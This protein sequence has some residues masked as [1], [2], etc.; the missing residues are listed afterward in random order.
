MK[1]TVNKA[2]GIVI[3]R[4]EDTRLPPAEVPGSNNSYSPIPEIRQP[5]SVEGKK[6][7]DTWSKPSE[8]NPAETGGTK[9]RQQMSLATSKMTTGTRDP[10]IGKYYKATT[11]EAGTG[12]ENQAIASGA[13]GAKEFNLFASPSLI[14]M[15]TEHYGNG[16]RGSEIP[17]THVE[18]MKDAL[19]K[20]SQLETN[21]S[22]SSVY[23]MSSSAQ[24]VRQANESAKGIMAD[25]VSHIYHSAQDPNGPADFRNRLTEDD[26]PE[27]I[28]GLLGEF[29]KFDSFTVVRSASNALTSLIDDR[30][31]SSIT[32]PGSPKRGFIKELEQAKKEEKRDSEQTVRDLQIQQIISNARKLTG[33][34][35]RKTNAPLSK[36]GAKEWLAGRP[37]ATAHINAISNESG[38]PLNVLAK[39][40]NPIEQKLLEYSYGSRNTGKGEQGIH[41]GIAQMRSNL[42]DT[43]HLRYHKKIGHILTDVL[44][45]VPSAASKLPE[46]KAELASLGLPND[47]HIPGTQDAFLGDLISRTVAAKKKPGSSWGVAIARMKSEIHD[48]KLKGIDPRNLPLGKYARTI[49]M[50]KGKDVSP[51]EAAKV[52][53]GQLGFSDPRAYTALTEEVAKK[54]DP[55]FQS[56]YLANVPAELYVKNINHINSLKR[57]EPPAQPGDPEKPEQIEQR[58]QRNQAIL[59]SVRDFVGHIPSSPDIDLKKLEGTIFSSLKDHADVSD[60][61]RPLISDVI[62]WR[63]PHGPRSAHAHEALFAGPASDKTT[64]NVETNTEQRNRLKAVHN[65]LYR[66]F[67]RTKSTIDIIS[68]SLNPQESAGIHRTGSVGMTQGEANPNREQVFL[69]EKR[70]K[71]VDKLES[72]GRKLGVVSSQI[73]PKQGRPDIVGVDS[74]LRH[75]TD[76]EKN[77]QDPEVKKILGMFSSAHQATRGD[78]PNRPVGD[79]FHPEANSIL[80]GLNAVPSNP[81]WQRPLPTVNQNESTA[82][83]ASPSGLSDPSLAHGGEIPQGQGELGVGR[84]FVDAEKERVANLNNPSPDVALHQ[85]E[86]AAANYE[87]KKRLFERASKVSRTR[88]KRVR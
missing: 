71:L 86:M 63:W 46:V 87:Y 78:L 61:E 41:P 17:K 66:Q 30:L 35:R 11:G 40:L 23:P 24:P 12:S 50:H 64:R 62:K 45:G 36:F 1:D 52:I 5:E 77:A 2:K 68:S 8:L 56:K 22:D 72:L 74:G 60:E 15:K 67:A 10:D 47:H 84:S 19:E 59:N 79:G 49:S 32:N 18:V 7:A 70:G 54:T 26:S 29:S 39:F 37:N 43:A 21:L 58:K 65:R 4:K 13:R 73:N 55:N 51:E 14:Q 88:R 76:W 53:G 16:K 31:R 48:A 75:L 42:L 20:L 80:A 83:T 27:K 57:P 69:E 34:N 82:V 9:P 6:P 25:L 38:L 3:R 44:S 81:S 33:E 28:R 85:K